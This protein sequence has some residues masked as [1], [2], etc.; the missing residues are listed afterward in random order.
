MSDPRQAPIPQQ[1]LN[2]QLPFD[3]ISIGQCNNNMGI[4]QTYLSAGRYIDAYQLPKFPDESIILSHHNGIFMNLND[5]Q[6][7]EKE[8]INESELVKIEDNEEYVNIIDKI[9]EYDELLKEYDELKERFNELY[10]MFYY[11]IA[12]PGYNEANNE[13]EK[14]IKHY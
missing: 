14:N 9:K 1:E 6:Q 5:L 8:K 7:N 2:Q 12:G 3:I 13:Y 10:I 11:S 4:D